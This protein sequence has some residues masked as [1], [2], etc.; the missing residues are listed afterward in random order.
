MLWQ[1][2]DVGGQVPGRSGHD[3]PD[4]VILLAPD[5]WMKLRDRPS[6]SLLVGEVH[7]PLRERL[8][9]EVDFLLADERREHIAGH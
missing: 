1:Y 3:G 5:W 9:L 8:A 7:H 2:Q 6:H 4:A